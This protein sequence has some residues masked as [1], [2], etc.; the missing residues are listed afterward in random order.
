MPGRLLSRKGDRHVASILPKCRSKAYKK[1][2][3]GLDPHFVISFEIS[4]L[5]RSGTFRSICYFWH[6]T[7]LPPTY[8]SGKLTVIGKKRMEGKGKGA[9]GALKKKRQVFSG[10]SL[11]PQTSSAKE[12]ALTIV[13]EVVTVLKAG[14]IPPAAIPLD[15]AVVDKP[16]GPSVS[17][18]SEETEGGVPNYYTNPP[19]IGYDP[20]QGPITPENVIEFLCSLRSANETISTLKKDLGENAID[21]YVISEE[22]YERDRDIFDQAVRDLKVMLH[23]SY[24]DFDFFEFDKEVVTALEARVQPVHDLVEDLSL[25]FTKVSLSEGKPTDVLSDDERFSEGP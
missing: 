4:E 7:A 5:S 22:C 21:R 18:G 16:P 17:F 25:K 24:P 8:V 15:R 14:S 2:S 3:I 11:L 23:N 6:V 9:E 1:G 20:N 10:L 12:M 13:S 19:A